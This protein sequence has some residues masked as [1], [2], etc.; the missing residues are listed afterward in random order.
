MVLCLG[1]FITLCNASSTSEYKTLTA[2]GT[3]P[4]MSISSK[5]QQ[6]Y[7]PPL[8]QQSIECTSCKCRLFLWD[9][10]SYIKY[11]HV[12]NRVHENTIEG[13]GGKK[14]IRIQPNT[15]LERWYPQLRRGLLKPDR[16]SLCG[17]SW[18]DHLMYWDYLKQR[19]EVYLSLITI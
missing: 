3:W 19:R 11:K 1:F 5:H 13:L 14:F 7:Q 12:I 16:C 17:Y 8:K 4:I 6:Q 18:D 15:L 9:I 10:V 2:A